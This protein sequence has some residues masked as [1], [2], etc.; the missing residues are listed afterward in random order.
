MIAYMPKLEPLQAPI[1]LG[2]VVLVAGGVLLGQGGR[3]VFAT[4]AFIVLAICVIVA[5]VVATPGPAAAAGQDAGTPP[6]FGAGWARRCSP[7]L[8]GWRWQPESN[9]RRMRLPSCRNSTIA[10][11]GGS[12]A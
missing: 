8:S 3:V 12:G 11:G 4:Q 7:S 6:L 1:E 10:R 2:L 9:P 5:G